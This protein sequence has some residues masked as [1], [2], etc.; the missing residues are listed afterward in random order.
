MAQTVTRPATNALSKSPVT[1][2]AP[3][4]RS[5]RKNCAPVRRTI[6]GARSGGPRRR[7][8]PGGLALAG[9]RP[10]FR[11][12]GFSRKTIGDRANDGTLIGKELVRNVFQIVKFRVMLSGDDDCGAYPRS[13]HIGVA[14]I[15]RARRVI[16]DNSVISGE[17]GG[18]TQETAGAQK[19][20]GIR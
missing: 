11:Q 10:L 18:K 13:D 17:T 8:P 12:P 4:A 20:L 2:T 19:L 5:G 3:Q 15:H 16:D 1:G 14:I 7:Q 9:R 6:A